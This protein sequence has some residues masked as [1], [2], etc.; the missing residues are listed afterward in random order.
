MLT[1]KR[2]TDDNS[3]MADSD[4]RRFGGST[5][6]LV[7]LV[8]ILMLMPL[9]YVGALGPLVWLHSTGRITVEENS[10]VAKAYRPLE[11]VADKCP[12]LQT[13][14]EGY[15]ALWYTEEPPALQGY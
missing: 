11:Y 13:A 4:A 5:A 14:V 2:G 8:A 12:P 3:A 7:A 1:A 10:L 9:L 15:V 6:I